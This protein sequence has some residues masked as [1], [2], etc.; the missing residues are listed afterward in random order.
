MAD[1]FGKVTLLLIYFCD[2]FLTNA[3]L[4]V[5]IFIIRYSEEENQ[6][7]SSLF[8]AEKGELVVDSNVRDKIFGLKSIFGKTKLY[9]MY[10][11]HN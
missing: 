11:I 5:L 2:C 8:E 4:L 1:V 9:L 7:L 10:V 3:T 6:F